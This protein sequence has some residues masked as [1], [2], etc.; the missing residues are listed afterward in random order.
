[1]KWVRRVDAGP[2]DVRRPLLTGKATVGPSRAGVILFPGAEAMAQA[3]SEMVDKIRRRGGRVRGVKTAL[4]Y[5]AGLAP[6]IDAGQ[7]RAWMKSVG[8]G[9][10]W[11]KALGEAS[12]AL[13]YDDDDTVV[14]GGLY[15]PTA[16]EVRTFGVSSEDGV[17]VE[18]KK[19]KAPPAGAVMDFHAVYTTSRKDR[20][21]DVLEPAGA[22]VDPS[23]PLLYMHMPFEPIGRH[24]DI[25]VQ[26]SKRLT[27]HASI[28]DNP[29]GNDAAQLVEFGALRISHGFRPIEFE[30][31]E[32]QDPNDWRVGFHVKTYEM[33]EVSLVSVP[34][35][36]D[37]VIILHE[38]GKMA[39]PLNKEWAARMKEALP[40]SVRGGWDPLSLRT[41]PAVETKAATACGCGGHAPTKDDAGDDAKKRTKISKKNLGKLSEAKELL[42]KVRDSDGIGKADKTLVVAAI[43]NVDDVITDGTNAPDSAPDEPRGNPPVAVK[44]TAGQM[45]ASVADAL[46]KG[47]KIPDGILDLL[48]ERATAARERAMFAAFT[49]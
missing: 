46:K 38:K 11:E 40:K 13:V 37:A 48:L 17:G 45:A 4:D 39:H 41:A 43:G 36:S 2:R 19:L 10:A 23:M 22:K 3:V 26:N 9:K 44:M 47:E 25:L 34:A 49:N 24:V 7:C 29:L 28:I 20:E 42:L 5:L 18:T 6:C 27:G 8:D 32:K 30:M 14:D 33:V 16:D 15:R 12:G 1:M 21:G 35:N 31:L